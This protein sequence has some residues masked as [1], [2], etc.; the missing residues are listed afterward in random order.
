MD[1][2][3]LIGVILALGLILGSIALGSAPFTAF[4]DIP[5][6]LVV[7]GGALA[8]ALIC[9]PMKNMISSPTVVMKVFV[10]KPPDI[11]TLIRQI[12]ELA[13]TALAQ[14]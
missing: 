8:A 4:M 12:V 10:N 3:S 11:Q 2:A 9:F 13:E 14:L 1:I 5:S 6:F 7:V